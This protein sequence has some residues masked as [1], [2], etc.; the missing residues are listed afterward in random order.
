[1]VTT[2]CTHKLTIVPLKNNFSPHK[3]DY[4]LSISRV[5]INIH[6][7]QDDGGGG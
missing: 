4:H 6:R 2:E 5:L 3:H 7:A 1:M